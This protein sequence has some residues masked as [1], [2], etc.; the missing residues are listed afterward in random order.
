MSE[1]KNDS[2]AIV[3]IGCR[4]PGAIH[5]L[6]QLWDTLVSG[7]DVV[8]EVPPERFDI[9][10][11]W[12]K[13]REVAGKTCTVKAG[14]VGDVR[15]YDAPFFNMSAKEAKML[16]PQ[17]R[18][19][20]EMAWE[21][22]EDAGIVPSSIAGTNTG[23]WV[24]AAS[25]DMG[26][27][28]TDD[29]CLASPYTMTGTSLS[30]IANRVSY[31]FDLHGPSMTLDT[32]CSSS[33]VALHEACRAMAHDGV[34]MA[35]VGG[36]NTLLSP[37]PF[38]GFSKAHM[39]SEDG[40][41]KVFDRSGNGYVRSEGGA[42]LVVKPLQAAR[43]NGDRIYAVI[44]A[45]G[46]NSDGKTTGIALPNGSAQEALLNDIYSRPGIDKARVGYIEAHGTG[47]AVGDPIE[48]GS[49]GKVLG[50]S[51]EQP[52][53][54][55]SVKG[56]LGHLETGS[57]M[58]GIAKAL[59]VLNKKTI[60]AN[61]N[62]ET[63]NPKIDFQGLGI[64]VVQ[65]NT[66]LPTFDEHTLVG[67]NSFG[68]GGTNAH[69]VLEQDQDNEQDNEQDNVKQSDTE[70]KPLVIC[71]K[72]LDS[73]RE[74]AK[75]YA[76]LIEDKTVSKYNQIA[77]AAATQREKFSHKLILKGANLQ[78]VH[79]ALLDFSQN[80]VDTKN[81][82][83]AYHRTDIVKPKLAYVY[84]GNGS[85]WVG[86]GRELYQADELFKKS[87][88]Q[89]DSYFYELS[90]WKIADQLLRDD[91]QWQLDLTEFSQPMLFAV[92]VAMT[93]LLRARGVYAQGVVGHSVGEVAGAWASGALSLKDAVKVIYE[94]SS[95][96]ASL[97]G[98]G[99]MA[100]VRLSA[101]LMSVL[102]KDYPEVQIAGFNAPGDFTISGDEQ[103]IDA[104]GKAIKAMGGLYKKLSIAYAF[105]SSKMQPLQTQILENLT[106]IGSSTTMIDFY[107]TVTG[108]KCSG[109]ALD[110]QYWWSN[111]RQPVNFQAAIEQML[112]D[113]FTHFVEVGPH[114]IL[115]SYIR[116][117]AKQSSCSV[118]LLKL[119]RRHDDIATFSHNLLLV[120]ASGC[121][122]TN[123]WPRVKPM[124]ELPRYAW[125][126]ALHWLEASPESYG[127]YAKSPKH[128]LL[129]YEVKHARGTWENQIDTASYPWLSGHVV[130]GT[131][132]FPAAAYLEVARAAS[133]AFFE[134]EGGFEIRNLLIERP[135]ALEDS[136][137]KSLRSVV[138]DRG[139]FQL[140]ARDYCSDEE[141]MRHLSGRLER[142]QVAQNRFNQRDFLNQWQP[143]NPDELYEHAAK[144]GLNYKDAFTSVDKAWKQDQDVIVHL[145]CPDQTA[146]DKFG[147]SPALVDGALQG[148]FFFLT[149]LKG[150]NAYLPTWFG[151]SIF[152]SNGVPAWARV[153]LVKANERILVADFDLYDENGRALARL[154]DVRFLCVRQQGKKIK[155]MLYKE[156]WQ[157]QLAHH[158]MT[159][160]EALQ[161]FTQ[162]FERLY[163]LDESLSQV[164]NSEALF[165]LLTLA[166]AYEAFPVKDE[167]IPIELL[168]GSMANEN[169]ETFTQYL[170]DVLSNYGLVELKNGQ[171]KIVSSEDVPDSLMLCR[172]LL[173]QCPQMWPDLALASAIAKNLKSFVLGEKN[174][175]EC[176]PKNKHPLWKK[177]LQTPIYCAIT[178][179]LSSLLVSIYKDSEA[180][181]ESLNIGFI[182]DE[183]PQLCLDLLAR[184][185]ESIHCH[186]FMCDES[187]SSRLK[188]FFNNYRNVTLDDCGLESL[189]SE[190]KHRFDVV[191]GLQSLSVDANVSS[192][193]GTVH[194]L[195]RLGGLFIGLETL[196]NH[197]DNFL[198]GLQS[199]WWNQ[200]NDQHVSTLLSAQG[201]LD[202]FKAQ[203]WNDVSYVVD[204]KLGHLG[205]F[206]ASNK[207][208]EQDDD[209]LKVSKSFVLLLDNEDD[210]QALLAKKLNQALTHL[211]CSVSQRTQYDASLHEAHWISLLDYGVTKDCPPLK[212]LSLCQRLSVQENPLHLTVL[213]A[214]SESSSARALMGFVR[215]A[216]NE[217]QHISFKTA[218]LND[219]SFK[220][221]CQ[222]IEFTQNEADDEIILREDQ[223][224]L[225]RVLP[226]VENLTPQLRGPRQLSFDVP[227][228][229][230]RLKWINF[231]LPTLKEHDVRIAVKATGLN[232]RDVMWAMGMLPEQALENGFSGPTMGLECSGI[233]SE[234]GS[235]VTQFKPGDTVVAFAPACF[236]TVVTTNDTAVMKKPSNLSFAQAASVPVAFFTAWYAIAY[237]ARARQAER[238]LIHGAAG[239][240]GLAAVQIAKLLG[241]EIFA[242]AG[243]EAK[244]ALLASLGVE[245]VYDSR[246]L[247][248]ADEILRDTHQQGVNIVLNSLA[249]AGAEK[250][251]S[252]LSPFGRFLE[253]GKRDFFADN[254]MFL[255]PFRRNLSYF[256]IDVDQMLV[257]CPDL[258][259]QIFAEVMSHFD[260]GDFRALPLQVYRADAVAQAF[261]SMQASNHIGKLVVTYSE[262]SLDSLCS[263][264]VSNASTIKKDKTYVITGGLGGLGQKMARGLIAQGAKS[265]V[266]VTRGQVHGSSGELIQSLEEL[267]AQ[268]TVLTADVAR[269]DF[270]VKLQKV[271]P[272]LPPVGGF[273]HTAGV[274]D[275]KK[276]QDLDHE[277]MIRTWS[278]KVLG[279]K[280]IEKVIDGL[281]YPIDFVLFFSSATVLMGNPGQ[282]NYVA[283]NMAQEAIVQSLRQ[284]G[285]AATAIGWGPVGDVGMLSRDEKVAES[286]QKML[287]ASAITSEEVVSTSLEVAT[288]SM[289]SAHYLAADWQKLSRLPAMRGKRFEALVQADAQSYHETASLNDLLAG[290]TQEESISILTDIVLQEVSRIM[291][292]PASDINVMQPVADLG[293]DSLMVVELAM[294]L[295]EKIGMK[296]PS[297]SLSGGATV[298]TI[299]ERFYQMQSATN[300]EEQMLDVMS[301]Q[302]GVQLTEDMKQQVLNQGK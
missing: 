183:N 56:N 209:K 230:D 136:K 176:F 288:T 260:K 268:I 297:V 141:W 266:L 282:A 133:E 22:F 248:F 298:K 70:L 90:G 291:G 43:E 99:S 299:A 36:V 240:V 250:S 271:L 267:G 87:I 122:L 13:N 185:P 104:M 68:F 170:L 101:E 88:D 1:N 231:E 132:L 111:V 232:F 168:F 162:E 292:M 118:E 54:I 102:Q 94:R 220:T 300:A 255:R 223:Q 287:G 241:L 119:M 51:Q 227:G 127:I 217:L 193:L 74:L 205:V 123:I 210:R 197:W 81:P 41:C 173:A 285:I 49:I 253:L 100:A 265:L 147:L 105:H 257:D 164:G 294:E 24:G 246:S 37:L 150:K 148:L 109:E 207:V 153:H 274:L 258:A 206:F 156:I 66:I 134:S 19:I 44:R 204:Q 167:W 238:I 23:V 67:V 92:E 235:A 4:F 84:S 46:V 244:R 86:M 181:G 192:M 154:Q 233:V 89:V 216:R 158:E 190:D 135:L 284:K 198:H 73:L 129:G 103:S 76:Q 296:I 171:A 189:H 225:P 97:L 6:D 277:A 128:S 178:Q 65:K 245:H 226:V 157:S 52:L 261:E 14:I 275:D 208:F 278:P 125:N 16:D 11:F 140:F 213:G 108:H 98:S 55:G 142:S 18:M 82:Y 252:I 151:R 20:L 281:D 286:L 272:S 112:S 29:I 212:T 45:T 7:C 222:L 39:L 239:G 242:T 160:Q 72:S 139:E 60:P 236:S 145:N 201:W 95:S 30:I 50:K 203:D 117:T 228:K 196:F 124:R 262:D 195:L 163:P 131:I 215:T 40:R 12:H 91:D 174:L 293:M 3:G 301:S 194:S 107:S 28:H 93:Q 264:N 290:K 229:L 175:D 48:T 263:V 251:L 218:L 83:C 269:P 166:Y 182:V 110:C 116:S 126:R 177:R 302:H 254:P 2:F 279:A 165:D 115:L 273:I 202:L 10:R 69:V 15:Y 234:V 114:A 179:V 243:T 61:I 161:R 64:R 59:L 35:L 85:Q 214:G 121:A 80:G 34:S 113:G 155:P 58:A 47:T 26:M 169:G 9:Q 62:L 53:L 188:V 31:F 283:A 199:G 152:W 256:G 137:L 79:H 38:V 295:E 5:S 21:A 57:G 172:T 180:R 211:H 149:S 237:L 159:E 191:L 289:Q 71:A 200:E 130:D 75:A 120:M 219:E 280:N 25:T 77:C 187:A 78:D 63:L 186:I 276:I 17:Q 8:S 138:S 144:L 184:L 247:A 221:C 259:R 42:V 106:N 96:Q 27:L 33:L 146:V 249:G 143:L 270:I 224:W 32:A